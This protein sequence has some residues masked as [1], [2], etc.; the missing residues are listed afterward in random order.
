MG[1]DLLCDRYNSLAGHAYFVCA[2]WGCAQGKFFCRCKTKQNK[3]ECLTKR[4]ERGW[5]RC[6][7][8]VEFPLQRAMARLWKICLA[9][10]IA[11]VLR[12]MACPKKRMVSI[13]SL[14]RF[15]SVSVTRGTNNNPTKRQI[16]KWEDNFRRVHTSRA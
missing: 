6:S 2:H 5:S 8:T 14:E 13:V 9:G 4:W 7:H 1:Q 11:P 10:L 12:L 15:Q 3:K 16:A